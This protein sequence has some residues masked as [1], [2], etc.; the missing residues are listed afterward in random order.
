MFLDWLKHTTFA[1]PWVLPLLLAVPYLV[2]WY[3]KSYKKQTASFK[4]TTTYFLEKR[5]VSWRSKLKHLPIVLRCLTLICLIIAL[6]RSQNKFQEQETN[7]EGID[8]V[9]CFDIS[10]SMAEEPDPDF[11]PNRLVNAKKIASEFVS[12][13]PGDRIGVV[14]FSSQSFTMCPITSD[15]RAVL[16][17]INNIENGY[18]KEDGTAIGSGLAT[19]VDRLRSSDAK[20]KVIILLTD[21]VDFGGSIPPDVAMNMAKTYGIK[22]YAIGIG[23][24]KDVDVQV[25][26][27]FGTVTQRKHVSFNEALLK[28]L[29]T[30]TNGQYF[31]ATDN[32][33]LKKVY[34]NINQLEKSKVEIISYDRFTDKYLPFLLIGLGLTVLEIVLRLTLLRKFP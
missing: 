17:Q 19:S 15:H 8:I 21:G 25:N 26:S 16:T 13:R 28:D 11:P 32:D 33:A 20:S 22:V 1:Y 2:Y 27:P 9:M 29:A 23:S 7:G 31:H 30:Q 18:L 34:G 5:R 24:E 3:I 6:A 4:I 14:I 12:N 10:G